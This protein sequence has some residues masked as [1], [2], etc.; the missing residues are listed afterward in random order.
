MVTQCVCAILGLFYTVL[1]DNINKVKHKS[2]QPPPLGYS[3]AVKRCNNDHSLARQIN[4][5]V[6]FVTTH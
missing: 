6:D 5:H 4:D 2:P 3:L 1:N